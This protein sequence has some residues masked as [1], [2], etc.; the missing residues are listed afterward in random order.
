MARV[1]I[2][3]SDVYKAAQAIAEDGAFPTIQSVRAKIGSGSLVT[4]HKHLLAWKQERLLA[5]ALKFEAG[6]D[7][8][9]V[10][11]V[12]H[13][14]QNLEKA[15]Q[16]QIEQNVAM[17]SQLL[18]LEQENIGLKSKLSASL[19]QIQILS[20]ENSNLMNKVASHDDLLKQLKESHMA[21][22]NIILSDK[23]AEIESLK[24]E[25]KTVHLAS[26]EMVRKTSFEGQD[27]LMLERVKTINLND[28]VKA[29][30]AKI[31]QLEQKLEVQARLD[32]DDAKFQK[33]NKELKSYTL[34]EIY[35]QKILDKK[36]SDNGVA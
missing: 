32:S 24:A 22:L 35:A 33:N 10:K 19:E 18:D 23:N 30:N 20:A 25:L 34:D 13:E 16:R 28:Q 6:K 7:A 8:T 36:D 21:A 11:S 5:P 26:I 3:Q 15:V 1:G 2:T 14:K 17:S 27:L 9:K 4:I 31:H 29:L 12:I